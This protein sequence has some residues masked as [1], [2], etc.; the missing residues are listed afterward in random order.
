MTTYT[1]PTAQVTVTDRGAGRPVLLLHGGA[2][3]DSVSGFADLLAGRLPLHV[4]TPVHPGFGGTPRPAGLDSV[5]AL[6]D[7]YRRLLDELDLTGVTVIGSSIG[8]W[9]AAELALC[10]EKRVE[11]LVLMDAAGLVSTANPIADFFSLTLDQV[12][13]LS[14]ADPDAHRIDPGNWTD[15]QKAI[16]GGN[17]A[18]LEVYGGRSM[19]DPSLTARL[20]GIT[21]P[22]LVVWGAADRMMTPDYG[23]EYAAA[24]PGA[25]FH[26]LPNAGHLPQI[27]TPEPLLALLA[28]TWMEL[29]PR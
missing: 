4:M 10:A 2:G 15:A 22:T 21:A 20:A 13:D 5:R 25:I 23:R 8:G 14:Y 28:P 26:I 12:V 9:I 17:R 27:E 11:R 7:V 19:G 18:A 24:I 6:A 3:P 1:L 29:P 16:A